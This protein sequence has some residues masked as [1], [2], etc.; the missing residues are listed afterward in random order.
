LNLYL[1]GMPRKGG[2]GNT[3]RVLGH[4]EVYT[5]EGLG[6][7]VENIS[8]SSCLAIAKLLGGGEGIPRVSSP[9][10]HMGGSG[11]RRSYN[12]H[13]LP[14][15]RQGRKKRRFEGK[16]RGG[17]GGVGSCDFRH[18]E[19]K[20]K[21]KEAGREKKQG[22]VLISHFLTSIYGGRKKRSKGSECVWLHARKTGFWGGGKGKGEK[23][24]SR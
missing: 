23:G 13:S 11:E 10:L 12:D 5:E 2:K 20:K 18:Q 15:G 9:L 14:T 17:G 16:K 4:P 21:G 22:K 6:R 19:E 3:V 7:E 8:G 1:E 24:I